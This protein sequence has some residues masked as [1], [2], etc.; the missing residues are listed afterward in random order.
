MIKIGT[1]AKF[2]CLGLPIVAVG[3][4]LV[5]EKSRVEQPPPP[6]QTS[7]SPK[8]LQAPLDASQWNSAHI[9]TPHPAGSHNWDGATLSLT[10]GGAGL[11]IKGKDQADF[12]FLRREAGDFEV[13]ARLVDFTGEGDAAAGIMARSDNTPTGAMTALV[14]KPKENTLGWLSRN[15]EGKPPGEPR[16]K[17]T[18]RQEPRSPAQEP[19]PPARVFASSIG[20]VKKPPLWIKMV[21][22]GK[23]F[24]VYKS[25]DGKLWAMIS[26]VSGGPIAI[27]GQVELG[28]FVSSAAENKTATARFD[29][30]QIGAPRLRYKTSWVGN[31]FGCRNDDNHV[32]N[33]LAAM[34]VAPDGICYTSSYW[35]EAGQPVTSYRD[36]KV[37]R[38]LPIGTPQTTEGGITGDD[39]H[40]YVAAVDRIIK[41]NPAAADFAPMPLALS[42]SLHDKKAG[43]CVVSGLASNGRELFVADSRDNVIRVVNLEPVKTYQV[44]T[45]AND[46]VELAPA[47]VT[48]P[49]DDPRFAP[50]LVYQTQR[51]GEGFRYTLPGFAPTRTYTV[52]GHFAE[53]VQRPAN[54]DPRSRVRTVGSVEVNVAELAGGVLKAVVKDFPGYKADAKGN[55]IVHSGSYGGPG[56]CGLEVLNA[57]GKRL[58]AINCGGPAVGD[59]KGESPELVNRNFSFERPGP[60]AID[61]RGDLWIIQR[62]NDHPMTGAITAKY[63]AAVK[64]YKTDGTFT[65]REI[66][67]VL[68]PRALGYDAAQDQLLVAENGPDLNV[69]FYAQLDKSPSLVRTFGEQ[70]GIYRGQKPGLIHDPAAGGSARFAGIAG[71]GFD[72]HGNL[73]IGGGF[74]GTD[75]RM[76]TP[77]GKL[78]W[79]LNSLMFCNTYDVDPA[80]DGSEIYGTYNHLRLD[81]SET[82]PGKEQKYLGY[83][84]DP[85]R[86]GEP[87]RASNSQAIVR[88][89]G[90]DKRLVMFTTGQGVIGDIHIY[91]YDGE[92]AVPAGG[93]RDNG[94]SL[95]IDTNG[96]GKVDPGET[97]KMAS[98]IS[99][100][101]GLCVD[102]RGD[103]W[104]A[105][106]GSAGSFMRH[107]TFKGFNASRVPVY[108]GAKGEGYEDVPF[109]EEGAQTNGW[110][111]ASR[112]DYDADRDILVAY[113]PA[114]ARKGEGDKSPPQYLMARYDNWSKGNRKSKWKVKGLRPET[115]PDYFMYEVKLYPYSGYMGMQIAGDYIFFA[116]L[117]GEVHVFDLGTGKLVEILAMGPEV[118]GQ[119]AWEDAAM[120]LRAFKTK[121]GE[122]LIFTENSGWGGK[123]NLFR[124]KP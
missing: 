46:G 34:W 90:P 76:F 6:A 26:N 121:A 92:I 118:N 87:E 110:S 10:G 50:A 91:R 103:I 52:R 8:K 39:R 44:A 4:V 3:V 59:F 5:L 85:R 101:T 7:T 41:L 40:V 1:R 106:T 63:K 117:F 9:G 74:Q 80:S 84:W 77:D 16:L 13:V 19:R 65:S 30:I 97:T 120:G 57:A 102:S 123:N 23:N 42:V 17:K 113:F 89:L 31:S 82:K 45:A 108:R 93:T 114:V 68:N 78:G 32:S 18:A 122:Y 95:W 96:N 94:S 105:N 100:I 66:T 56:L 48:V 22:V 119:C 112:M 71:V 60:M 86:F 28:F 99:W 43:Q 27:A 64:C 124:W 88:R 62:G 58:L 109:P 2:C 104:A 49:S 61:K 98:P 37:A 116:Y 20:L 107:F 25:R 69:R 79:M 14:F 38:P 67:D 70:T 75:L 83:N 73:Y 51:V 81:L 53:Y 115:D 55:V 11:N 33:N 36:G 15:P 24:A 29:S 72:K 21:R 54:G 47:P 111:M 35:D 12:T